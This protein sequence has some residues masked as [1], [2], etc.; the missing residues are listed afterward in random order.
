MASY[1]LDT[2]ILV[3]RVNAGDPHNGDVIRALS[4]LAARRQILR[5]TPQVL[6]EF[7]RICARPAGEGGLGMAHEEAVR[8]RVRAATLQSAAGNA[9]RVCVLGIAS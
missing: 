7:H 5:L 9:G 2:N 1:L 3:A 6:I 8:E 4:D